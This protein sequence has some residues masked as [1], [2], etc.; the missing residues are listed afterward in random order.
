MPHTPIVSI[1]QCDNPNKKSSKIHNRNYLVYIATRDGVDLTPVELERELRA[2]SESDSALNKSDNSLYL[3]YINERP[4]SHGLFGNA[5][6]ANPYQLG[7]DLE[8]LTDQGHLIYRGIVS[9]S[10]KDALN[11]GFDKKE[12]W[13]NYMNNVMPD[14]AAQ[15]N[16]PVSSLQWAAAF[17][18]KE[19]HPHCHYMFWSKEP[20]VAS[21]FIHVSKQHAVRELLS[22]EMYQLEREQAIINKTAARDL[23]VNS[24]KELA[25]NELKFLYENP[26]KLIPPFPAKDTSLFSQDILN[27]T[28]AL[29]SSGQLKYNFLP[30]ETKSQVNAL[31]DK[32]LKTQPLAAEYQKYLDAVD[33]VSASYSATKEHIAVTHRIADEDLRKRLGNVILKSCKQLLQEKD[34]LSSHCLQTG[35]PG[36]PHPISS[37]SEITAENPEDFEKVFLHSGEPGSPDNSSFCLDWN[38]NYKKAMAVLYDDSITDKSG[39]LTLLSKEAAQNNVLALHQMAVLCDKGILVEKNQELAARYY[40]QAFKGFQTLLTDKSYGKMTPYINYRLGKYCENGLGIEKNYEQATTYYRNA[41]QN[42][43]AQYA[44]GSMYLREKGIKITPENKEMITK[45]IASLFKSSADAGFSY[46]GYSYA[47]LCE[48]NPE[49]LPLPP[50]EID[51]YYNAALNAFEKA[52]SEQPDDNLFY[53]LGTMYYEGKGTKSDQE[54]ALSYFLKSAEY[55]NSFAQYALGKTYSDLHSGHYDL[56]KAEEM[57]KLSAGQDNTYAAYALGKLYSDENTP[58]YNPSQAIKYLQ[59]ASEQNNDN[60]QFNLAKI[61]LKKDSEY[62]NFEKGF[63]LLQQ[64]ACNNNPYAMGK[65]GNMYLWGTE[66]LPADENLGKYWLNKAIENGNESAKETLSIYDNYQKSIALGLTFSL[67][68]NLLRC[69]SS[70]QKSESI[71]T[72]VSKVFTRES[73]KDREKN[74]EQTH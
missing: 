70:R 64:T 23:L 40:E 47:K 62:Y 69:C 50:K 48:S 68:R 65:L 61:Y 66:E 15:F 21:P 1:L 63:H 39:V 44:L 46:A 31:V 17:H 19:G 6:I 24:T 8:K 43:Y 72:I 42:K 18:I 57:F 67:C 52:V 74:S 11:L 3:K 20:K 58:L 35:E 2:L 12:N 7:A 16:I 36:S 27:L 71:N 37:I 45:E 34:I 30:P 33:S 26:D 49:L 25:T 10:E 55:N 53:R 9:L 60:A 22:K 41:S 14:I 38:K 28:T 59:I 29:P 73:A 4:G 32:I 51:H 13:M 5:D 54:T 56:A